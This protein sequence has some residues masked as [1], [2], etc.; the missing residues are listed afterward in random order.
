MSDTA[1]PVR[2]WRCRAPL[3]PRTQ[4]CAAC[5]AGLKSREPVLSEAEF[6]ERYREGAVDE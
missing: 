3:D 4:R 2:C 6:V 5:N 1:A